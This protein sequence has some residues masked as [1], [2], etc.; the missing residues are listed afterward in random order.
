MMGAELEA[1]GAETRQGFRFFRRYS[2]TSVD[3][4]SSIKVILTE[5]LKRKLTDTAGNITWTDDYEDVRARYTATQA[6]SL[7]ST[8]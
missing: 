6:S 3:T 5:A 8:G 4:Q 2:A 1:P 7:K